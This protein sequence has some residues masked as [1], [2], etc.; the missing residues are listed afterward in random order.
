[1]TRIWREILIG[2]YEIHKNNLQK[3]M[4]LL[5]DEEDREF[6]RELMLLE[7]IK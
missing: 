1:M 7:K 5:P 6:M 4:P 3:I 2:E